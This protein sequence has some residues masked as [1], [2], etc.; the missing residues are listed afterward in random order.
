MR[1]GGR[2]WWE[3]N[4]VSGGGRGKLGQI[5]CMKVEEGR[6]ELSEA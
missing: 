5:T 4:W 3:A 6:Q 1:E 2:G